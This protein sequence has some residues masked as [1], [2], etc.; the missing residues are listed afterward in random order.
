MMYGFGR[1]AGFVGHGPGL[2]GGVFGLLLMVAFFALV[3]A[4]I[5]NVVR[6][7]GHVAGCCMPGADMTAQ[8]PHI[9]STDEALS[10]AR[11]RLARGEIEP[12]QYRAIVEALDN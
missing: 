10:I 3:I 7:H 6:H 5:V 2:I 1:G 9:T 8:A 12:E 11:E 4:L